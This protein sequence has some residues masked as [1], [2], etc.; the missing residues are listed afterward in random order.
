MVSTALLSPIVFQA[1]LLQTYMRSEK[2]GGDLSGEGRGSNKVWRLILSVAMYLPLMIFM[3]SDEGL[4]STVGVAVD[5]SA[6]IPLSRPL[7]RLSPRMVADRI[8]RSFD[9]IAGPKSLV[10]VDREVFRSRGRTSARSV[11]PGG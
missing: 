2:P 7:L 10:G 6:P 8:E 5:I 9:R 3:E 11:S 1:L 4:G